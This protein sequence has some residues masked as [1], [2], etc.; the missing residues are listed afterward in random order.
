MSLAR[1]VCVSAL[2]SVGVGCLLIATV[3]CR[4]KIVMAGSPGP[5][6]G[7]DGSDVD[8]RAQAGIAAAMKAAGAADQHAAEAANSRTSVVIAGLHTLAPQV[9]ESY[10]T[11]VVP[12]RE[13]YATTV[14]TVRRKSGPAESSH[15]RTTGEEPA[16]PQTEMG[17]ISF[18]PPSK[19]TLNQPVP[20][21]AAVR[22]PNGAT[23]AFIPSQAEASQLGLVGAGPITSATLPVAREM[24]V[25]LRSQEAGAFKIDPPESDIARDTKSLD[26][27]GHAQWNW[28]LT[29]LLSG[30][31]HLILHSAFVK[32]LPNGDV[33]P[34]DQGNFYSTINVIVAPWYSRLWDGLVS[35]IGEHW[36]TILSY[37]LPASAVPFIAAW[38]RRRNRRATT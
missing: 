38:W 29:P 34:S 11:T 5:R 30:E 16:S 15:V 36:T 10:T 33:R 4:H 21:N 13:S 6:T 9:Q 37:F 7:S 32:H 28:V 31:K 2:A 3:S 26:P 18:D 27:G 24:L 17:I 1:R 8:A 22:W 35:V 14:A 20:I 23:E 19:M 25:T 12:V